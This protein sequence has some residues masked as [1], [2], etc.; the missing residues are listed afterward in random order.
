MTRVFAVV[1]AIALL[2]GCGGDDDD[3]ASEDTTMETTVGAHSFDLA[4]QSDL[5]NALTAAKTIA[6]DAG[7][8]FVDA[9]GEPLDADDLAAVDPE[10]ALD[11]VVTASEG[12]NIVLVKTSESGTTFCIAST[13][14]GAVT[15]GSDADPSNVDSIADCVDGS[16]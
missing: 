10:I 11:Q 16:W 3:A 9:E 13:S 15:Y 5:R 12:A 4:V 8:R 6:V 7:G 2:G 14:D 1:A